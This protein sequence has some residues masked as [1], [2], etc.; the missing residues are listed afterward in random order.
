[1]IAGADITLDGNGASKIGLPGN[2]RDS[3]TKFFHDIVVQ[4][5]YLNNQKLVEAYVRDAP[6]RTKELIDWGMKYSWDGKRAVV[7]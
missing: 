1:M 3:K 7:S 6:I 2:E 4:G 5:F